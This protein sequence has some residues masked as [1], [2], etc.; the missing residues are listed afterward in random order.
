MMAIDPVY[1]P[2]AT[3]VQVLRYLVALADH[4]HFGRAAQACGVSQPTLSA[5]VARWESALKVQAFDRSSHGVAVTPAGERIVAAAR[6]ALE[7]LAQVE[8]AAG[9][10]IPPFY[11]PVRLGVIPTVAPYLLPLCGPA[12][13]KAFPDAVLPLREAT[14]AECLDLLDRGQIDVAIL[15][16]LPGLERGRTLEPLYEEPFLLGLPRAHRL[17]RRRAVA[18]GDLAGERLLLLD[19]GH[20]LRGQVQAACRLRED[21]PRTG[22]DY[23][24]T[25]LETLRHLVAGGAGV[26]LFPALAVPERDA[27]VVFL[28]FD[29]A[30]AQRRIVACWRADDGREGAYRLLTGPIRTAAAGSGM[31]ATKV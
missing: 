8:A 7:A 28:P 30:G 13:E 16:E 20:C 21:G 22:A 9:S 10:A 31:A 24:A 5:L 26:S 14:T 27:R 25:S 29:D 3:S 23:R 18:P 12:W 6:R 1:D 4:R 19:D 15:A 17:A 2:Q 11:G